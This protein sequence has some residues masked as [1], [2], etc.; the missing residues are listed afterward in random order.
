MITAQKFS[1]DDVDYEVKLVGGA[2][3]VFK[4]TIENP[5]ADGTWWDDEL[6]YSTTDIVGGTKRPL[7]VYSKL[8]ACVRT[9]I[10]ANKLKY[11]HFSVSDERRAQIYERFA[12]T[13]KGYTYDRIDNLFYLF[14]EP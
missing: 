6:T 8:A 2:S 13:V 3:I 11:C 7:K 9:I 4:A 14:R 10:Y 5:S 1:I 12:K